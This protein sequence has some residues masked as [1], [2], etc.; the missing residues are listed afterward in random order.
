MQKDASFYPVGNVFVT[1][2]HHLG[3]SDAIYYASTEFKPHTLIDVATL[4]GFVLV[5]CTFAHTLTAIQ[6]AMVIALG[7]VFSGVFSV[8]TRGF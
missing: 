6:R 2:T 3:V 5:H 8:G 1:R 7:E 4:T